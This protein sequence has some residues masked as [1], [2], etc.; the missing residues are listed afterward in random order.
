MFTRRQSLFSTGV[1][2]ESVRGLSDT[3]VYQTGLARGDNIFITKSGHIKKRPGTEFVSPCKFNDRE[4]RLIPFVFSENDK[5]ILEFGHRYIRFIRDDVLVTEE[6]VTVTGITKATKAVVSAA[7]HGFSNGDWVFMKNGIREVSGRY[8]RVH[9]KTADTFELQDT[10]LN[11]PVISLYFTDFV[12]TGA[13]VERV[14]EIESPYHADDL[15]GVMFAQNLNEL[16]LTHFNHKPQRLVRNLEEDSLVHTNWTI[17]N[18]VFRRFSAFNTYLTSLSIEAEATDADDVERASD[19][20]QFS[21]LITE[22]DRVTGNEN[23]SFDFYNNIFGFNIT[24][25]SVSTT[26]NNNRI[27][28]VEGEGLSEMGVEVTSS[29]RGN[30]FNLKNIT[31]TPE[32]DSLVFQGKTTGDEDFS[33]SPFYSAPESLDLINY[34]PDASDEPDDVISFSNFFLKFSSNRK[35]TISWNGSGFS[36]YYRIYLAPSGGTAASAGAPDNAIATAQ[37]LDHYLVGQTSVPNLVIDGRAALQTLWDNRN[38]DVT[39]V[40]NAGKLSETG[41]VDF[42]PRTVSYFSQRKIYSGDEDNPGT[43]Y[44]SR[45]ADYGDFGPGSEPDAGIEHTLA[46][47]SSESVKTIVI[48][49]GLF[50]FTEGGIWRTSSEQGVS[51]TTVG[52]SKETDLVAAPLQPVIDSYSDILFIENDMR[53]V[54]FLS[55]DWQRDSFDAQDGTFLYALPN[56]RSLAIYN[57]G[58]LFLAVSETGHMHVLTKNTENKVFAWARWTTPGK[59]LDVA[60]QDDIYV[61][62]ERIVNT[63]AVRS[64]ERIQF[65]SNRYLDS[66]LSFEENCLDISRFFIEPDGRIDVTVGSNSFEDDDTV[67]INGALFE[68]MYDDDYN[69]IVPPD[70][71]GQ[72]FNVDT[73]GS[74]ALLLDPHSDDLKAELLANRHRLNYLG[75]GVVCKGD[76]PDI[77]GLANLRNEHVFVEADGVAGTALVDFNGSF[78]VGGVRTDVVAGLPYITHVQ[79]LPVETDEIPIHTKKNVF[80][81]LVKTANSGN[82][83]IKNA[84]NLV[85]V[86]T[87]DSQ[88]YERELITNWNSETDISIIQ[89]TGTPLEILSVEYQMDQGE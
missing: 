54:R 65:N 62:T 79:F 30:I 40:P 61:V 21:I 76:G 5:Y 14:Y 2:D 15:S 56:I 51:A 7:G 78:S 37:A 13:T 63:L 80:K 77:F 25:S 38:T 23:L 24:S 33:L 19:L 42:Q 35:L 49:K 44:Y 17:S 85:G 60:V 8:F 28:A 16:S 45:I 11:N 88:I 18:D 55:Y 9:S 75:Q 34:D 27:Q 58:N 87:G 82:F 74:D 50:I 10:V 6:P 41:Y 39:F 81:V 86:T 57:P 64:V 59:F 72:H 43:I 26:T 89:E 29:I 31:L 1:I 68:I 32:I 83:Y 67:G 12:A 69:E 70:F 48:N 66:H 84:D 46:S 73:A 36:N 53:T 22:Y 71:T 20:P 47:S 4:T 52:Y 3:D